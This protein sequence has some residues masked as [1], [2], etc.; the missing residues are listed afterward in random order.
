MKKSCAHVFRI[1]PLAKWMFLLLIAIFLGIYVYFYTYMTAWPEPVIDYYGADMVLQ[2]PDHLLDG[3]LIHL[4]TGA[5]SYAN[6]SL[7]Y[8]GDIDHELALGLQRAFSDI[9]QMNRSQVT[10]DI[11]SYGGSQ[12][13]MEYIIALIK[14]Q[15]FTVITRV[16]RGGHCE[17]A[18]LGLF[19][20]G[21]ERYADSE[22][23]F[24]FH[25]SSLGSP[26]S[27]FAQKFFSSI[28]PAADFFTG[29]YEKFCATRPLN[30]FKN[31]CA[32]SYAR[33]LRVLLP[34]S[35][36]FSE[37]ARDEEFAHGKM[38]FWSGQEV[39]NQEPDFAT[40][41]DIPL[42]GYDEWFL[43]KRAS[44]KASTPADG[45]RQKQQ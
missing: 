26:H 4:E 17:S 20:A 15:K 10:I 44:L 9:Q 29:N 33:E 42:T 8:N 1:T 43:A 27:A 25:S 7:S 14:K 16:Y 41:K 38:F 12:R 39:V 2:H 11:S 23:K 3:S 34:S 18:C 31:L 45:E 37:S 28:K 22:A 35:T 32:I 30:E 13:A 21:G 24:M 36:I 5:I 40:L 6:G 19:L